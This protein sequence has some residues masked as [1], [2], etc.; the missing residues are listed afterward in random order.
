MNTHLNTIHGHCHNHKSSITYTT[1]ISM[2]QRCHHQRTEYYSLRGITVCNRW[3]DKEKG[4]QNFLEDMGERPNLEYSIDRKDSGKNYTPDNCRWATN[5]E[6]MRNRRNNKFAT[7]KE[8]TK[9][10]VEWAEL[11]NIKAD[12]LEH[13]LKDGWS[14][15]KALTTPVEKFIDWAKEKDTV[16]ELYQNKKY[17]T[18]KI[19]DL[20]N[21]FDTNIGR[22][23]KK[24]GVVMR[25]KKDYTNV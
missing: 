20:Y 14:I 21:T 1:W 16:I 3:L 6:Q 4:F 9:L 23:L 11:Y 12:T 8:E 24:N 18:Y 17:S 7:F 15:E 13:R 22:I 25:S 2:K 19:A 10:V 5:K